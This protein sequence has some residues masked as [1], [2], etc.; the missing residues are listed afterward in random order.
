MKKSG[1]VKIVIIGIVLAVLVVGYFFYLSNKGK[2]KQEEVVE[3]TQVQIVLMRDLDKNYPPTPKEVVKYF[4]EISRCFYNESYTDDELY[5]LAMKIQGLYDEELIAN[6]TEEQYLE[7]LKSDIVEMK[8]NDRSISSYE[9]SASTDVEEFYENGY[10]CAR[11]YC[12]YNI[13]QG[14]QIYGSRVVFVLR[15]DEDGHWK[16]FGWELDS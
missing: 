11:L 2:E 7:D 14:T 8:S 16:I 15:K 3:S 13:R 12:T 1:G 6:K 5:E 10:S 9:L 4:S